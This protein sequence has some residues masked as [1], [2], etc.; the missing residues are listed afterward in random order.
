[1]SLFPRFSFFSWY[2]RSYTVYFSFSTLMSGSRHIPGQTVFVY[3]FPF[4]FQVSRHI[5]C[6]SRW[7]SLFLSWS[8]F[9]PYF[10]SY[11]VK[12]SHFSHIS[13]FLA[14]FY[15]LPCVCLIFHVFQF[16]PHNPDLQCIFLIFHVIQCLLPYSRLYNVCASFSTF[17]CLFVCF[18]ATF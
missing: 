6:P 16:S 5:L 12:I 1:M 4:F 13:M 8:V 17:I 7:F 10:R 14:I 18:F 9:L 15:V 3:H 2:S 11:S